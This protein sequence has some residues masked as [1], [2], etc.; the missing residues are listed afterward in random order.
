VFLQPKGTFLDKKRNFWYKK[1]FF[2]KTKGH[3]SDKRGTFQLNKDALKAKKNP[4][5]CELCLSLIYIKQLK[6]T[7]NASEETKKVINL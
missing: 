1:A 2:L 5:F 4:T 7:K 6:Q 3:F